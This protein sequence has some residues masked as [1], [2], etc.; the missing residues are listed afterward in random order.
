MEDKAIIECLTAVRGIGWWIVEMLLIFRLGR[1]DV[2][3]A[4]D[5][6]L[7]KGFAITSRDGRCRLPDLEKRGARWNE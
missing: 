1:P 4:D 2:L 6:G 3:L 5:Y 7:R